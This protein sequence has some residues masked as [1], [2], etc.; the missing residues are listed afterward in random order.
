MS[1]SARQRER[2]TMAQRNGLRLQK[3]ANTLLD[4]SRV[5]AGRIQAV[6]QPTDRSSLTHDLASSFRSACDKAG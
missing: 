3:L 1:R 4:F 2:I 6:Y 5:G